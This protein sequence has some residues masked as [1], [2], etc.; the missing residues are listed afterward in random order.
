MQRGLQPLAGAHLALVAEPV[1]IAPSSAPHQQ[2][3]RL[4]YLALI[5]ISPFNDRHRNAVRAEHDLRAIG[6]GKPGQRFINLLDQ[7]VQI[8]RVVIE[9]LDRMHRDVVIGTGGAIR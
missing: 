2:F 3:D 4:F 8:K 7:G 1:A 9:R 5:G 6:F